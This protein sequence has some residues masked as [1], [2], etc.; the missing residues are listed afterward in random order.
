MMPSAAIPSLMDDVEFLAALESL[1]GEPALEEAE[2]KKRLAA[3][4]PLAPPI[5]RVA[6]PQPQPASQPV[7]PRDVNR[8]FLE[9][10]PNVAPPPKIHTRPP[11]PV[12]TFAVMFIGASFG[13]FG[14]MLIFYDRLLQIL[15][16]WSR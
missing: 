8:W 6:A 14:A 10:P 15:A 12:R 3:L 4:R 2:R 9:A 11:S 1:E 13:A 16:L 7:I 5:N